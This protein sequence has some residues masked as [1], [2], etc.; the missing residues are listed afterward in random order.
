MKSLTNKYL[1]YFFIISI[2]II[3]GCEK[4]PFDYRNKYCGEW[5]FTINAN[6]FNMTDSSS[7]DTVYYYK[8]EIW[9]ENRKKISIEYLEN[10]VLEFDINKDGE[11]FI[12]EY[13][14]I[15]GK[16]SDEHNV[17]FRKYSGGLGAGTSHNVSGVKK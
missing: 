12:D 3:I 13:Y 5:D 8:G 15:T 17:S 14:D 7:S 10:I 9:Y 1:V 11:I 16:F 6:S 2:L 4:T